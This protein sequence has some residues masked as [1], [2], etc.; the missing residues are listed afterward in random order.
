MIAGIH[1]PQYMPWLGY[2]DKIKKCDKF[3]FLDDVQYKKREYQNR[4]KI[5]T[6]QGSMWLTIP[7]LVKGKYRQDIKQVKINN[8]TNW[9]KDHI[10]A[11]KHNY[12]SAKYFDK[13]FPQ[14]EKI[15]SKEYKYLID[16][17]MET[18]KFMIKAFDIDT[19]YVFSSELNIK[20]QRTQRLIDI[21]KKLGADEYLSGQGAKDYMD[22]ELFNKN[23]IKLRYQEFK[24]PEYT[25]NF[26]GFI[27][28]LSAIDYLFNKK[29]DS[30]IFFD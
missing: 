7:V 23:G 14:I 11:I 17:N 12:S 16:I 10:K 13:Y 1:Q 4:N 21:C 6:P 26:D 5:R 29:V 22:Q 24:H 27:P 15:F 25:Q 18:I 30:S 19:E 9:R 3:V 20:S 2:I 28:N 8:S